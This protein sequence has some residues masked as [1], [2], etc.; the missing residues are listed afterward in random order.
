MKHA[1]RCISC[2]QKKGDY[3]GGYCKACY[4]REYEY[5]A[6]KGL[7]WKPFDQ[8]TEDEFENFVFKSEVIDDV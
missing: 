6:T 3:N 4:D 1:E 2:W 8:M 7:S 5:W